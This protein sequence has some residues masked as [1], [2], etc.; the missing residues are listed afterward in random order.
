VVHENEEEGVGEEMQLLLSC[1]HKEVLSVLDFV[2]NSVD[3][4]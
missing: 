1:S 2:I 3:A 4:G